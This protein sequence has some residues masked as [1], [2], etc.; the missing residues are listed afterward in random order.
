MNLKSVLRACVF[1]VVILTAMVATAKV[2][3]GQ[4]KETSKLTEVQQLKADNHK[5]KVMLA[6]YEAKLNECTL[7]TERA[8]LTDDF[9]KTLGA[10]PGQ[11]FDWNTLTVQKET[12]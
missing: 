4:E 2:Y 11:T 12:K 8:V 10:A 3:I 7:N 9:M 5:L 6:Q 1:W